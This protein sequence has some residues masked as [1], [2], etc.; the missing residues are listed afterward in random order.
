MS[1]Y[2]NYSNS[3]ALPASGPAILLL[4]RHRYQPAAAIDYL[5]LEDNLKL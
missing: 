5:K 4:V 2:L 3:R 1:E